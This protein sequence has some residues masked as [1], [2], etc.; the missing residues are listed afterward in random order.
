VERTFFPL[1]SGG[2]P[3]RALPVLLALAVLA[4]GCVA[5][6]VPSGEA[7]LA[8]SEGARF[9]QLWCPFLLA[10][11]AQ[12][13]LEVCN[14]RAS[15]ASGP[16]SEIDLAMDPS[17]PLH[18]V[19]V[20]KAYNYSRTAYDQTGEPDL[21]LHRDV[22]TNVMTTFD[23]GLTWTED[24]LHAF[25]PALPLLGVGGSEEQGSDPIVGFLPDGSL[26]AV[27]LRVTTYPRAD[28]LPV[29]RSMDGGL[30]WGRFSN[31]YHVGQPDKQWIVADHARGIVYV[32]T[33]DFASGR[34]GTWIT[35]STDAGL[36]WSSPVKVC[37]CFHPGLDV[38]PNGE[39]HVSA[40]ASGGVV[41]TRSL[42]QG[43]TWSAPLKVAT[44]QGGGV[45][46]SKLFRTPNIPVLAASKADGGVYV[47]YATRPT[48]A[49]AACA[50]LAALCDDIFLAISDDHGL[51]WRTVRINDDALPAEQFMPTVAVSPNGK[52]VHVGWMDQRH[53]PSG[54][55]MH[56]YYAHSPDRGST[57]QPNLRVSEAPSQV[58]TSFH[59]NP[60]PVVT[61]GWFVGD[62]IGL[63]A[64]DERAVIAFPD[65]RYGRADV[66]IATVV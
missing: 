64:S 44:L 54:L 31:A 56:A 14:S 65:T 50:R 45:V 7:P 39:V 55:T 59:Q 30:T 41:V 20:A 11:D 66:A 6:P 15:R 60:V 36:T 19:A 28:S 38:G 32:A 1:A 5:P 42:D 10:P 58:L 25:T 8:R 53:D 46:S 34:S 9:T 43:Q 2:G 63:Q 35:R 17:N 49:P 13:P 62:Y 61:N 24:Y 26:L 48:D 52:D 12:R 37:S 27:T 18:L 4:A 16:A 29:W 3:M 23:G 51:T 40:F 57:W 47:A 21:G 22:I 33:S